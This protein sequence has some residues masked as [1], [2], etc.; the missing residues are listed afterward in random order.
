LYGGQKI[1]RERRREREKK[2]ETT[3]NE[4]TDGAN[5]KSKSRPC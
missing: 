5:E 1:E 4:M 2:G 3:R